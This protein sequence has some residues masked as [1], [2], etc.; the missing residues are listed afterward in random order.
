MPWSFFLQSF[1]NGA[2]AKGLGERVLGVTQDLSFFFGCQR[3]VCHD[4]RL[5]TPVSMY[6]SLAQKV[7]TFCKGSLKNV[8]NFDTVL[9]Q[10][11]S[12]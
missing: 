11:L 4:V 3:L 8:G 7:T 1:M 6:W 10:Q 12:S 9:H 2:F 5:K